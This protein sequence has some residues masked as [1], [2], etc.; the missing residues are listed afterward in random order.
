MA[1]FYLLSFLVSA[2]YCAAIHVS[3]SFDQGPGKYWFVVAKWDHCSNV[4]SKLHIGNAR[5]AG[6]Q[7]DLHLTDQQYQICLTVLFV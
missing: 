7:T 2:T 1:M 3:Y 6:L 5:V 4:I